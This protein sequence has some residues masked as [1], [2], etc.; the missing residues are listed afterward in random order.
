[1]LLSG[2]FRSDQ[3][4]PLAA[5]YFVPTAVVE[6]TLGRRLSGNAPG[7][8]VNLIE[9]GTVYSERVNAID[10][11]IAKVLRFGRTRTN[12][13]VDVYNLL[14]SDAVLAN[15]QAFNPGGS[16]LTPTTVMQSRFAKLSASI[17]F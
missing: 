8:S 13:G 14:N 2:T 7:I 17:D 6:Q 1:M 12:V 11:K 16:W 3:G 15:N 9:P 5:N 4:T 10:L